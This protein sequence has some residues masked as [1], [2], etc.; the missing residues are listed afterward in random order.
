MKKTI[1]VTTG[2]VVA[3]VLVVAASRYAVSGVEKRA[4]APSLQQCVSLGFCEQNSAASAVVVT[5]PA[6]TPARPDIAPAKPAIKPDLRG[7]IGPQLVV[8]RAS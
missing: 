1:M 5:P 3:L 4:G 7:A 6:I 2:L 8:G